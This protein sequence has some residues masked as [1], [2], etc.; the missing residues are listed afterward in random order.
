MYFLEFGKQS[1]LMRLLAAAI[2]ACDKL[3][4]FLIAY[5]RSNETQRGH[6]CL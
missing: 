5:N 1:P 6:A 4:I 2:I 3:A